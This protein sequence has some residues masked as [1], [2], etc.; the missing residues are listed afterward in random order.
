[1]NRLVIKIIDIVFRA[2]I[3][4]MFVRYKLECM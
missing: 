4:A 2:F 1:M 3:G